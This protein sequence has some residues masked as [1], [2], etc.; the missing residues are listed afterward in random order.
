MSFS[1]EQSPWAKKQAAILG[2]LGWASA[3]VGPFESFDED[4]MWSGSSH[5]NPRVTQDIVDVCWLLWK[6][7]VLSVDSCHCFVVYARF[8]HHFASSVLA[9]AYQLLTLGGL[10][11]TAAAPQIIV[12][13][14]CQQRLC[15]PFPQELVR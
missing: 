14:W 5:Q 15:S 13:R 8:C 4:D 3:G 7:M 9:T 2:V 11:C 6:E 12:V 1:T 10:L